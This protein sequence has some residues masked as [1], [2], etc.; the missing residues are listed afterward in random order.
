M[1]C[2]VPVSMKPLLPKSSGSTGCC[3]WS[4]DCS[5]FQKIMSLTITVSFN[6]LY[7]NLTRPHPH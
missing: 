1:L 5:V 3:D 2:L 6:K 7:S 4:T